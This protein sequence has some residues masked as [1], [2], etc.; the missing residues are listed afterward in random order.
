[1]SE[2]KHYCNSCFT[3]GRVIDEC[4]ECGGSDRVTYAFDDQ[5][6]A[7]QGYGRKPKK[8]VKVDMNLIILAMNRKKNK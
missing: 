5:E 6:K 4:M 2:H 7:T 1:M 8:Q 3:R